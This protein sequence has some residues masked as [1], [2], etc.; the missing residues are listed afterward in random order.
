MPIDLHSF[1]QR[2]R[3]IVRT[4]RLPISGDEASLSESGL[5]VGQN[6]G[7]GAGGESSSAA[8]SATIQPLLLLQQ[9]QRLTNG[10]CFLYL[11][12]HDLIPILVLSSE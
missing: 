12:N 5:T 1:H 8:A 10:I 4:A 11:L 3:V 2:R 6:G 9:L 7:A